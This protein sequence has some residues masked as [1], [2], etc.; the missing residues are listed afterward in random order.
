MTAHIRL[1]AFNGLDGYFASL[2]GIT[3]TFTRDRPDWISE[4]AFTEA[5]L[6]STSIAIP[7]EASPSQQSRRTAGEFSPIPPVNTRASTS[8]QHSQI[9]SDIFLDPIAKHSQREDSGRITRLG[10][11]GP[12]R[13]CRWRRRYLEARFHFRRSIRSRRRSLPYP[14][15]I[16]L[17]GRV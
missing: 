7:R 17:D 4:V 3:S 2:V 10:P 13:A 5:W 1:N 15:Q 9:R 16:P 12:P 8:S 14:G 6:R 11:F